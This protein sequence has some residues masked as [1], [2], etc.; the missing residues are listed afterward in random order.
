MN[1]I[2]IF[3]FCGLVGA[4][5]LQLGLWGLAMQIS[6]RQWPYIYLLIISGMS[7]VL[8][9]Q[10]FFSFGSAAGPI[11]LS[12]TALGLLAFYKNSRFNRKVF[13]IAGSVAALILCIDLIYAAFPDYR[14]DQWNYHLLVGKQIARTGALAFPI[15]YDH[16]YF[17][18]MYE[19]L[20]VIPRL[21]WDHD[22]FAHCF[23]NAF[24]FLAFLIPLYGLIRMVLTEYEA[25]ERFT[26]MLTG[27]I[28]FSIPDHEV[29]VSSKPDPLLIN[30]AIGTV[31]LMLSKK[32]N[33]RFRDLILPV[34][35]VVPIAFKLTYL[36]FSITAGLTWLGLLA[37]KKISFS[38]KTILRHLTGSIAGIALTLPFFL[39]N[40]KFF[41][42]PVHPIQTSLFPS[43][44]WGEAFDSYW[45]RVSGRAE[46]LGDYIDTIAGIPNSLLSVSTWLLPLT[47]IVVVVGWRKRKQYANVMN[48]E[49]VTGLSIL[50]IYLAFW[51]VFY[52]ESIFARFLY[53][54][55]GVMILA[56][57]IVF[58]RAA[59][60]LRLAMVLCL[61]LILNSSVEVKLGRIAQAATK[62]SV[63]FNNGRMP[64]KHYMADQLIN[65]H[66]ESNFPD[67]GYRN[68]RV[69]TDSPIGYFLDS[70]RLDFTSPDYV[71]YVKGLAVADG[72]SCIWRLLEKFE[73]NYLRTMYVKFEDWPGELQGVTEEA[74]DLDITGEVKF[75]APALIKEKA[76][77]C[78]VAAMDR[79]NRPLLE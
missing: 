21:I 1:K 54:I 42:N 17:S 48:L 50:A 45:R 15:I 74:V 13:G 43:T 3:Q 31:F 19:F 70:E 67:A 57:L 51:P 73:I 24:S 30:F 41:G 46:G 62:P 65:A 35:L 78:R 18:G 58:A 59:G 56:T 27:A 79:S 75:I 4:S 76:E 47:L 12:I 16:I 25:Q 8:T 10:A 7:S 55:V 14:Y 9:L 33:T 60:R 36:H 37:L 6:R 66:K 11:L 23:S 40:Y 69:L 77:N 61:P 26:L 53:P 32:I 49:A 2:Y 39:K 71:Q 29:L 5:I 52:N 20:T 22:I 64:F 34:F 63:F 28:F 38:R 72:Y 44:Y 68:L